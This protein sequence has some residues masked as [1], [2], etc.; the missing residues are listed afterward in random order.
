MKKS[1]LNPRDRKRLSRLNREMNELE[2]KAI[3]LD[4]IASLSTVVQKINSRF[5]NKYNQRKKLLQKTT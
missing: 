3:K 1:N 5:I 4:D 2:L